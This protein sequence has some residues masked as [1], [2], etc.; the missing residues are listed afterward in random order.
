MVTRVLVIGG[1]GNFG[2]HIARELAADGEIRLLVG[3]RSAEKAQ[4]FAASLDALHPA[5]GHALDIDGDLDEALTRI[6]PD[7][8]IHT[9]GPFQTQ[10]HRVAR[11]CIARGCHYLD[12]ADAR[13]FVATIDRLD[14]E[15]K[16]KGVLVVSGASSVP[17]LTA[18]V[19]DA[20]LPDFARLEAVDYGISTAQQTNRGLATTSAVLSYVGKPMTMLRDGVMKTVHG[21]EDSHAEH[22]P[23]LGWRL[24]GNCDIPDLALF[25]RRYPTLKSMRFAAGHELKLLHVGTRILGALVR[26]RLIGSLSDHAAGLLRLAFLFNRF[27]S[28]RSGF[29][30]ILSGT[31]HDGK[32]MQR[33]FMIIARSGHGAHIPCVPA[34]LLARRLAKGE[35]PRCGASPCVDLIDLDAYLGAFGGLDISIVRDAANA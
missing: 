18:A 1:Y 30:M 31:G 32:P 4:A 34:I 6:A 23:G 11:A 10:D 21:W 14:T 35:V 17:C 13:E 27:G 29:H 25:P 8:V 28:G 16:A 20:Y 3:G 9:T 24:F 12:L 33:R 2:S 19:I 22:Y 15:A 26:M 7:L 5:E